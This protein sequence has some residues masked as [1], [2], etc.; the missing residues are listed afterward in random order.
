MQY[1]ETVCSAVIATLTKCS[2]LVETNPR[3]WNALGN[4]YQYRMLC[5]IELASD[6]LAEL[7]KALH[8]R[9]HHISSLK[10]ANQ[11]GE[12]LMIN[13]ALELIEQGV[14]QP[15]AKSDG[16]SSHQPVQ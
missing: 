6:Q 7:R 1:G 10:A 5:A 12:E 9:L 4:A 15:T 11:N 16:A 2:S 8:C 13:Q 14:K 3:K